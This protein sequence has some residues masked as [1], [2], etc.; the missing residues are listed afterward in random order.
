MITA[1]IQQKLEKR[2]K[3][4]G[5]IMTIVIHAL[6]LLLL[7]WYMLTPPNP[8]IEYGGMELSV[9]MG[10][11]NAGGP[12]PVP[13]EEP[14]PVVPVPV[15]DVEEAIATQDIEEAPAVKPVVKP[16]EV[17]K[18]V[19]VN[20]PVEQPRQVDERALFKKKNSTQGSSGFGDGEIPGNEGRADGVPDGSP[21]GNGTGNGLG[22]NGTGTGNGDGW[23]YD[24]KGRTLTKRPVVIDNSRETGKVVVQ[25]IVDRN[26]RVLKA[27]PGQKGTT[28]SSSILW[29]KA[30]QGALDAKF[31]ARTDG[32]DEQYGTMT[33]IFRYKP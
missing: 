30:K 5:I 12:S 29:E 1:E 24:L 32:P 15:Q 31:T 18:P 27:E 4:I 14:Q 9:S 6:L 26:G 17:K 25:I 8:P 23:S 19:K 13:V 28:T 16:Q 7:L 22:G 3:L 11:L 33:F 20:K 10:E 2:N 21:D